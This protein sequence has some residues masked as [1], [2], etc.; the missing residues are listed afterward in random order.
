MSRTMCN[1]SL[2]FLNNPSVLLK[3]VLG[4]CEPFDTYPRTYDLLHAFSLFSVEQKRC[5]ITDIMLEMDRIL[6]PG[7]YA[8]I[9]DSRTILPKLEAIG[10][11]MGWR[12]RIFDT[13]EGPY[14]SRKVLS[15]QKPMPHK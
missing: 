7:G 11:A 1:L 6:R 4:R 12:T 13:E 9:R 3:L 8:Y 14:A 2:P 10:K 5:D 15:C